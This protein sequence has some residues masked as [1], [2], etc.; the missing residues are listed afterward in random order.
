MI[1]NAL[2]WLLVSLLSG[3]LGL[4]SQAQNELPVFVKTDQSKLHFSKDSSDFMGFYQKIDLLKKGTRHRVTIAH[5]GGSHLQ[6]GFW[7][8]VL[9]NGFQGLGP[10]TG[11]GLFIFPFKLVKTNSPHYFRSFG[12]GHWQRCRCALAKEMCPNLGM[13]GMAGVTNDSSATFGFTLANNTHHKSMNS[14]KVF[15]DF[16]P[17]FELK[18]HDPSNVPF[19]RKDDRTKGYTEFSFE[20]L[21]DS[22][23]FIVNKKDTLQKDFMLRGFSAENTNPGFYYANMGVN[24]ASTGSFLRC[25]EFSNELNSISPDLVIFSLGVNDTHDPNFNKESFKKRYDS[26]ITLV[27]KVAPDC[28]ILLTTVTDNYLTRKVSNKRPIRAQE[29]LYELM[30]KHHI[31]VYDL[32][33][34]MGGYK[35]IY[36]WYKAGLAS[37][38]KV[39][40]NAKG[41]GIVG[42]LLFDAIERSYRYHSTVTRKR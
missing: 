31:A 3:I 36:K 37:K 14:V 26:L 39:H 2:T 9:M 7:P 34:V 15:H 42:H 12:H 4:M 17:S 22:I 27:K 29:A 32:Y 6:A 20:S 11:G 10:Y 1:T 28:A 18:L 35:S 16:N 40:F 13:A 41:Y 8:E 21:V 23:T 5:F 19:V 38:D 24:G 33:A 30:E 25:S